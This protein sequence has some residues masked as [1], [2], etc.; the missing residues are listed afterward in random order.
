MWSPALLQIKNTLKFYFGC[1]TINTKPYFAREFADI[2]FEPTNYM[3]DNFIKSEWILTPLG[4]YIC[5]VA[6]SRQSGPN[7]PATKCKDKD[8]VSNYKNAIISCPTDGSH[9]YT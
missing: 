5:P 4:P 2:F 3:C 6:Q 9:T 8:Q 1:R 7:L